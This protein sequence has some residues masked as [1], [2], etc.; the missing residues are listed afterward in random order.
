MAEPSASREISLEEWKEARIS[1]RRFDEHLLNLRRYGF[2]LAPIM[3]GADAYLSTSMDIPPWAKAGAT[4]AVMML[5]FAL[6]LLDEHVKTL[7]RTVLDRATKLEEQLGMSLSIS[8]QHVAHD[9]QV[10]HSGTR[11]YVFFLLAAGIVGS[12]SVLTTDLQVS[13][14]VA[15]H[16]WLPLGVITMWCLVLCVL[17][18][19][20]DWWARRAI[21]DLLR[22][23]RAVQ[24]GYRQKWA[25]KPRSE[26][27]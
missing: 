1:I 10:R 23:V 3:I 17:T 20:Y 22:P 24:Q 4:I 18:P 19:I 12:M 9:W 11:T 26:K 15:L 5:I 21:R 14:S 2:T 16:K 8:R 25:K 6:F 7:Q 13:V 27:P